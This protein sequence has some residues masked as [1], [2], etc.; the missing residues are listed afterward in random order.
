MGG[1]SGNTEEATALT[2]T[3]YIGTIAD[4]ASA[5]ETTFVGTVRAVNEAQIQSEIGGRVTAVYAKPGDTV[6]AGT[7]LATL[8]NA[9]QRAAL[10]QAQGSYEATLATAAQSE[11]SVTDA[12]NALRSTQNDAVNTYRNIVSTVNA[13]VLTAVDVFYN[14]P[15]SVLNPNV[16]ISAGGNAT[17]LNRER[18]AISKMLR[19]W[20]ESANTLSSDAD[21]DAVFDEAE[22]GI[23]QVRAVVDI[24]VDAASRSGSDTL[25]DVAIS[26]Y[27]GSLTAARTTLNTTLA[28]ITDI[29]TR[30]IDAEEQLRRAQIG[31][32]QS[33]EASLANAQIKQ[34]LGALRSAEAQYEKTVFRTPIAGTVN[35]IRVNTGDFI[36]AFTPVAEVANNSALQISIFVSE[37]DVPY[38]ST[39][40]EVHINRTTTGTVTTIAPAIDP[41]TQKIEVK[42]ATESDM[43]TNGS[44]VTVETRR[45]GT[46]TDVATPLRIPITAVKFS[47]TD[48]SVFVIEN[49]TL[50]AVPVDVG[51]VAGSFVTIEAGMT[52]DTVFVLDARGL[53][54]GQR[55]EAMQK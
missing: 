37:Q 32:T 52:A 43:L 10:L 38:F 6:A 46:Q 15:T 39:G 7:I 23:H 26:S 8:E 33:A 51:T 17:F 55:V 13:T 35:N 53:T 34:S 21:F 22:A 1:D 47:A 49:D 45:V 25:D 27:I 41:T 14:D 9:S 30:L 12:E 40:S 4:I 36:A 44:T 19:A 48:G 2:P 31:G 24:F 50:K 5:E 11:I 28:D 20:Q 42:I 54:D 18:V 29:E 16:R 3:V